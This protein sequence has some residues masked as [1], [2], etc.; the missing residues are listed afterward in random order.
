MTAVIKSVALPPPS[1]RENTECMWAGE[2]RGCCSYETPKPPALTQF[3]TA[4][5]LFP[6]STIPISPLLV[7]F[8]SI[9]LIYSFCCFNIHLILRSLLS[10]VRFS[11]VQNIRH[12]HSF[13]RIRLL[14][15]LSRY[16]QRKEKRSMS[17]LCTLLEDK[18]ATL[19]RLSSDRKGMRGT[20]CVYFVCLGTHSAF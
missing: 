16:R 13:D 11:V 5:K 18:L 20:D 4:P 17:A 3:T 15:C 9:L 14:D 12:C 1:A 19:T 10:F 8:V 6:S 7:F 2:G